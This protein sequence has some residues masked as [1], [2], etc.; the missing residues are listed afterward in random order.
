MSQLASFGV[1]A[2]VVLLAWCAAEL[3]WMADTG[4]DSAHLFHG[5]K[6]GCIECNDK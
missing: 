2:C 1:L 6:D 5:P 3:I 4:K